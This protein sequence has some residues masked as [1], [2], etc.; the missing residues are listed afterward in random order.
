MA[1][2]D[3]LCQCA[4]LIIAVCLY[5][6]YCYHKS[7]TDAALA[8]PDMQTGFMETPKNNAT[9]AHIWE[10]FKYEKPQ[11]VFNGFF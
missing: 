7:S 5:R 10:Q 2:W 8:I 11:S 1:F 6:R 4:T 9:I 3:I